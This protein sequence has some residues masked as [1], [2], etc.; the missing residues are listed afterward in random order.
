MTDAS[1]IQKVVLFAGLG[2]FFFLPQSSSAGVFP[3]PASTYVVVEGQVSHAGGR[4]PVSYFY[5]DVYKIYPDS[6]RELARTGRYPGGRFKAYLELGYGHTLKFK[7]DGKE[8]AT[9]NIS[10]MELHQAMGQGIE[11]NVLLEQPSIALPSPP[12]PAIV[13]PAPAAAAAEEIPENRP[14]AEIEA[15]PALQPVVNAAAP[16]ADKAS[17][18][19]PEKEETALPEKEEAQALGEEQ[20]RNF[21]SERLEAPLPGQGRIRLSRQ[22]FLYREIE[23]KSKVLARLSAGSEVEVLERTTSNWWMVA[24]KGHIGWIETQVLQ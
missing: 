16:S 14:P 3:S 18:P 10:A 24:H 12:E 8:Q 5:L 9:V 23:E 4:E 19:R 7:L 15:G 13:P 17:L 2:L 22:V 11:L 6:R 20:V 21:L 1:V